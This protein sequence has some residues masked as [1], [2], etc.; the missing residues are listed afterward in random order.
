MRTQYEL[1][2]SHAAKKPN[3]SFMPE[4]KEGGD[5]VE[6]ESIAEL[7]SKPASKPR[8]YGTP[9]LKTK[10]KG[11]AYGHVPP[12]TPTTTDE[13]NGRCFTP[14]MLPDA[15]LPLTRHSIGS[16]NTNTTEQGALQKRDAIPGV[17]YL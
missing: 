3:L 2:R 5:S 15:T 16:A 13:G 4:G 7:S 6:G 1:P 8:Q 10:P 14:F 9:V 12:T 17:I 11:T